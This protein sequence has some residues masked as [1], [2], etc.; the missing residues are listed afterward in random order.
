MPHPPGASTYSNIYH[1]EI[2]PDKQLCSVEPTIDREYCT[3]TVRAVALTA[4][5]R[6]THSLPA[7][8][9]GMGESKLLTSAPPPTARTEYQTLLAASVYLV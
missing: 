4:S 7:P 2:V 5:L 6:A 8:L 3:A 9:D 1:A